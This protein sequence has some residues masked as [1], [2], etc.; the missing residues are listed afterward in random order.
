MKVFCNLTREQASLY[1]AVVKE[2]EDALEEA[3]GIERK[4]LVLATLIEAEAGLQ[5]PGAVPERQLGHRRAA[6]ASWRG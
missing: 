2:A 4:G 3:E 1:Q 6:P 5:S